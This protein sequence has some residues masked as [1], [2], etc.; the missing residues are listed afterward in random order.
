MD[1][2]ELGSS[3]SRA[4]KLLGVTQAE[5]AEL[6]GVSARTLGEVERGTG[7]PSLGTVLAAAAAVGLTIDARA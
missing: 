2:L 5:L 7:S 1:A 4:R 3:I 6:V